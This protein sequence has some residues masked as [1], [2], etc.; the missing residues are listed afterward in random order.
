MIQAPW[1]FANTLYGEKDG[2]HLWMGGWC[3]V[4]ESGVATL[5]AQSSI[6]V[7]TADQLVTLRRSRLGPAALHGFPA[8]TGLADPADPGHGTH[9]KHNYQ[10]RSEEG[11][12]N[13]LVGAPL[14]S[15]PN[16]P[17]FL[18]NNQRQARLWDSDCLVVLSCCCLVKLSKGEQ[19]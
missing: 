12:I 10:A 13:I 14:E 11:R 5:P 15:C 8:L 3:G 1:W 6:P 17:Q 19:R 16:C 2:I 18:M 4:V 9:T 7:F